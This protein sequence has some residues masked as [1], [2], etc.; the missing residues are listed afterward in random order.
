[1]KRPIVIFLIL[2][3]LILQ[4][5][6]ATRSLYDGQYLLS[7]NSVKVDDSSFPSGEL[8][9]YIR[10]RPNST[11][12][13]INPRLAMYS[14]AGHSDSGFARFLR[15][16]GEAPV[17]Y[18]PVKVDESIENI[19]NHLQYIGYYGSQVES[20]ISVKRRK[21]QV[22]YYVS[23]G[24]QFNIS[25]ID[26]D[27]PEYGSFAPDFRKAL[28]GSKVKSGDILAEKALEEEAERSSQIMRN[29]GYFDF[30]K[31]FYAFEAD[32]LSSD[33]KAALTLHLRD[34]ALGDSPENAE[35]HLKYTIG[36]VNIS[37][38][39]RLKIRPAVL[40]NLNTLRP[41]QLFRENDVNTT[42]SRLSN[43]GMLSGV[44]V[45]MKADGDRV[46]TDISLQGAAMQG[47]K[48]NLE[49]SVNSTA[50]IGISPQ[51]SYFHKN[52]FHGGELLNIGIKGNFQFRPGNDAAYSTEVSLTSSLRFPQALG[53]PNRLFKGPNIPQT[54]LSLSFNYQDRPEF[55][56]TMIST[57]FTYTGRLGKRF[58]YL[59]SPIQMNMVRMFDINEDFLINVMVRNPFL[60]SM[61]TDHFDMGI[62]GTLYYSTD[63]STVPAGS[64]RNWRLD[65]DVSGNFLS[66][67]NKLMKF[68]ETTGEFLIWN[69]PYSQ[70]VRLLLSR[71][72]AIRLGREGKQAIAFRLLAG[73]GYGYGNSVILP[74]EKQFYAGGANSMRG[75]QSRTLGPGTAENDSFFAIPSQTGE[76]RLEANLE[77]RFPI[78]WKFE[79]AL[80]ADAGN[81]WDVSDMGVEG[82]QITLSNLKES[83]A[84]DWGLGLRLNMNFI[85]LRLDAGIKLHDPA[86][87]AGSRWVTP[88]RW[89]RDNNISVHFGVG[90]PF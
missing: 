25:R 82:G 89:F 18:D 61:Y 80:F 78:I 9:S 73:F 39:E 62:G 29:M 47:F 35:P 59:F 21:V 1:M 42:Y 52:L 41:G 57:A 69:T 53:L 33:G 12:L 77:Y 60:Y 46:N 19:E 70:Y 65:Y 24:K 51:F 87:A 7:R 5:C 32:T 20:R 14:W 16:I 8:N 27:L 54:D 64:Y 15:K 79:G 26:Y 44:N 75:W 31:R 37:H 71:S 38:P 23:L 84:L 49:A 10:Q 67:F 6:S 43:L 2:P 66:L 56:R 11:L 48:T 28:E 83:I 17:V 74:F 45:A 13:G 34:Y 36:E 22:T 81:I 88:D 90:Y 63:F 76:C 30:N 68:N 58:R 50:L 86:K 3:A 40:E 55:R 85:L 72:Q 4:A